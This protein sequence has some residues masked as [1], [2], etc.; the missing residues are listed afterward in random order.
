[1]KLEEARR[2][3]YDF[4]KSLSDINRALGFA[5][6]AVIWLFKQQDQSRLLIP[7]GL[8]VATV[9][10]VASLGLDVLQYVWSTAAWGTLARL[11]EIWRAKRKEEFGRSAEDDVRAPAGINPGF[12][13]KISRLVKAWSTAV[14]GAFVR[15]YEKWREKQ[16]KKRGE[17]GG[18]SVDDVGAPAW[19]NRPTLLVFWAKVSCTVIAYF[20][21]LHFLLR[22]VW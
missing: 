22:A 7:R 16:A 15:W 6:I 10:I 13:V 11:H 21:I 14:R 3:Y 4:S 9:M 19:I 2:A 8:H 20:G 1:M 18:T 17:G 5:G 12:W